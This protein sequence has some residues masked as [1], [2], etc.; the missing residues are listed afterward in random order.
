MGVIEETKN[1]KYAA[2]YSDTKLFEKII[3]FAKMAG[4]KVIYVALL[5]YYALQKP[6]I[7]AWAKTMIIGTLGYFIFPV[8]LIPDFMPIV[9][10]TDDFA[11]LMAALLAVTMYIDEEVKKKAKAKLHDWFGAYDEDEL[12]EVDNNISK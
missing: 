6:T 11:A 1:P 9:G 4:I 10:Y 7:P 3:K 2:A 5:L 12:S 8:D